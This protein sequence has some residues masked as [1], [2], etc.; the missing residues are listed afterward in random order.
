MNIY[1][2][3]KK[4]GVSISTVSRVIN[5]SGAVSEKT[6]KKVEEAINQEKFV[7]NSIARSLASNSSKTVGLMVPDVRNFFHAQAAYELTDLL[8]L[9]G[10]A[11]I[12]CNTTNSLEKKL[13]SLNLQEEKKVDAIITVGSA[14][15]EYEFLKEL[16]KVS[17]EIPVVQVNNYCEGLISIYCDEK[18]GMRQAIKNFK[19]KGYKK[20][21]FIS[22]PAK[23]ETRAYESKKQGFIEA[24]KEFYPNVDFMQKKVKDFTND[25]DSIYKFIKEND[26]DAIQFENDNIA[27]KFLKFFV[28]NNIKIPEEIGLVGFDNIDATNYT[29]KRLSSIDHK[30]HDYAFVAVSSLMKI[31]SG[32]N[33][34]VGYENIIKPIFVEK[35]TT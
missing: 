17:K 12:L 35:E 16:K 8:N 7:P 32:K 10:Y 31:L 14:Y 26:I 11:T 9:E 23:F 29:Y 1:D 18:D 19:Y 22:Q 20:P 5:N 33:E 21:M 4:C 3:A 24:L 13:T 28:D 2:I 30:L 27:I 6:R 15:G 25:I 34:Y